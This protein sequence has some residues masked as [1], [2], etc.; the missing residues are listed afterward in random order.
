MLARFSAADDGILLRFAQKLRKG[1]GT[2][3]HSVTNQVYLDVCAQH[4]GSVRSPPAKG[5]KVFG[6][7]LN[8]EN[9]TP[10]LLVAAYI[11]YGSS[12]CQRQVGGAG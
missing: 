2:F 1:F 3:M 6:I 4:G 7:T 5:R 11:L 12:G 10:I 8:S 9:L